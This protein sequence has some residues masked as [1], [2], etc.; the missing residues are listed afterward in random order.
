MSGV[1]FANG[2]VV[3]EADG[4]VVFEEG[5]SDTLIDGW[6][7]RRRVVKVYEF[8]FL[9]GLERKR[10]GRCVPITAFCNPE[11]LTVPG[12]PGFISTVPW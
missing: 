1:A 2:D 5:K 9:E 3:E 10:N 6:T 11:T 8:A 7:I 4:D 12:P